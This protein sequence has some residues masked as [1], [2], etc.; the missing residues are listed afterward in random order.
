M[1]NATACLQQNWLSRFGVKWETLLPV[2]LFL[3]FM[4][5]FLRTEVSHL[6]SQ[7]GKRTAASVI[8]VS[9]NK[10]ENILVI[11]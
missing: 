10:D 6:F 11:I 5:I 4:F 3:G 8:R 2:V 7:E 9:Q 1:Q